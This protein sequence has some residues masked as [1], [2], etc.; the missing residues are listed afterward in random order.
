MK[1]NVNQVNKSLEMYNNIQ[2]LKDRIR[3][4]ESQLHE[5]YQQPKIS[6]QKYFYIFYLS[7][8]LCLL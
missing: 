5:T 8:R 4:L 1:Q 2:V 3:F 6:F 7:Y